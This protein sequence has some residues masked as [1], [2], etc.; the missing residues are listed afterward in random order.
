V[1]RDFGSAPGEHGVLLGNL[2]LARGFLGAGFLRDALA[3]RL[4][5]RVEGLGVPPFGT[6]LRDALALAAVLVGEL[7][8]ALGFLLRLA[9]GDASALGLHLG[10][11]CLDVAAAE[12]G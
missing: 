8:L 6:S 10:G 9:L 5:L 7:R 12:R 3:Q 11:E 2:T 4:G 1:R